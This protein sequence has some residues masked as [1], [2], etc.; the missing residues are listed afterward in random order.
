[1]NKDIDSLLDIPQGS[2]TDSN[3]YVLA[4]QDNDVFKFYDNIQRDFIELGIGKFLPTYTLNELRMMLSE[5]MDNIMRPGVII[6]TMEHTSEE[7]E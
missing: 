2:L 4:V 7:T 5:Q 3:V 1:M 6:T